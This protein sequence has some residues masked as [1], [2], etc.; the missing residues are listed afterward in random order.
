VLPG[1]LPGTTSRRQRVHL[2]WRNP[3]VVDAGG[4]EEGAARAP[5]HTVRVACTQYMQRRVKSFEEF[6]ENVE[7]FVDVVADYKADFVVFP[8]L[9]TLQLLS[10]ENKPLRPIRRS[11]R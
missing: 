1:Y 9:F 4:Q 10:I 8:E 11:R 2:V 6:A 5:A 3:Q 7:Y